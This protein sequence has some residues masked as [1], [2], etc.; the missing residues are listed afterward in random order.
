MAD[1]VS[2][3]KLLVKEKFERIEG[4]F[5]RHFQLGLETR[6]IRGKEIKQMCSA[7]YG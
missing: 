6:N 3:V 2:L 4:V 5:R 1:K 7:D